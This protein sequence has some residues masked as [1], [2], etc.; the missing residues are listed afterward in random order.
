MGHRDRVVG[1]VGMPACDDAANRRRLST[2]GDVTMTCE[3][4]SVAGRK[5]GFRWDDVDKRLVP[6]LDL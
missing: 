4:S 1:I 3:A 2:H 5:A 6:E